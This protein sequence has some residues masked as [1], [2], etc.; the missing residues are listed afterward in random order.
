MNQ[1]IDTIM[2]HQKW[3]FNK[4]VADCFPN[5]LER[6][7]PDYKSMRSLVY[8]IG[9]HFIMP[10]T[11]ITDIGCSTGLAIEP[12]YHEYFSNNQY[13]LCD[14]SKAMID[15]CKQKFYAG[16]KD[17][18]VHIVKNNI[19]DENIPDNQSLILSVLSMQFIPTAYRQDTINKIY[20]SLNTGGAF[21]FV[22]KIIADK[23]MNELNVKL[24]YEMKKQNGYTKQ[25]ILQKQKSLENVLSPLKSK[26]NEDMLLEAGFHK[27]DMFWR[28]L[29]FCGWIAVK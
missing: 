14:N 29:N 20:Q 2:P 3:E 24:Y 5:M 11:W 19:F 1:K 4:Q 9:K 22:E 13:F 25:A 23:G 7:I 16:I 10:K 17:G 12:F 26:W 6:S 18:F 8:T 28:C 21:V 27:V 15:T